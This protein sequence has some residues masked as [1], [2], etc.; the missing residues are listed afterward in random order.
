MQ[1][2]I[3]L[4]FTDTVHQDYCY[5]IYNAQKACGHEMLQILFFYTSILVLN[6]T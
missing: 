1:S 6:A 2:D 5:Y 3:L 4:K